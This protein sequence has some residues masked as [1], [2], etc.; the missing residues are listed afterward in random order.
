MYSFTSY[1]GLTGNATYYLKIQSLASEIQPRVFCDCGVRQRNGF[2]RLRLNCNCTKNAQ[3]ASIFFLLQV[4]W[5]TLR[6]DT[7][8]RSI[9]FPL[10]F[11]FG[12]VQLSCAFVWFFPPPVFVV[13][14]PRTVSYFS[15]LWYFDVRFPR[16]SPSVITFQNLHVKKGSVSQA[17]QIHALWIPSTKLRFR[18]PPGKSKSYYII[19]GDL[20]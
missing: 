18:F 12:F 13:Q 11:R 5:V 8:P 20:Q 4:Q 2:V 3:K 9:D 10:K 1:P 15:G 19:V 16:A 7:N 14:V 17:H 6:R